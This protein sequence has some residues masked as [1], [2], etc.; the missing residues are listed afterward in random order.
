MKFLVILALFLAVAVAEE[1][2]ERMKRFL[3]SR[4]YDLPSEVFQLAKRSSNGNFCCKNLPVTTVTKTRLVK[5]EKV[6]K[7]EHKI[8]KQDCGLWGLKDCDLYDFK[9]R[10]S[11]FYEVENFI[12]TVDGTCAEENIVCCNQYIFVKPLTK[13]VLM[14]DLGRIIEELEG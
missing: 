11:Y 10:M 2:A 6:E 13:C 7:S 1:D 14:S 9:Y 8:G 5:R 3:S 4:Q 12:T